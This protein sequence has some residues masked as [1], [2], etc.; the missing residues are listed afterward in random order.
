MHAW[1]LSKAMV[2]DKQAVLITDKNPCL[3]VCG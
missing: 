3:R 2:Y 1:A